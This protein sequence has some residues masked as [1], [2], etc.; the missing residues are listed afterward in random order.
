M[1]PTIGDYKLVAEAFVDLMVQPMGIES[2]S[3]ERMEEVADAFTR[4]GHPE[5]ADHLRKGYKLCLDQRVAPK[6]QK[7]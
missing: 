7:A 5:T 6:P 1:T 4:I 3:P 2:W